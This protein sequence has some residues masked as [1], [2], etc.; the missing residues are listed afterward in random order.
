MARVMKVLDGSGDSQFALDNPKQLQEARE[1]FNDLVLWKKTHRAMDPNPKGSG[2][3]VSDFDE[4]KEETI[5]IPNLVG[6]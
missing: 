5:L 4:M 2:R 6:G 1:L 3:P